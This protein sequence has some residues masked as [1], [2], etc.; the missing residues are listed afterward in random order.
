MPVLLER[1]RPT[2]HQLTA[3]YAYIRR[4][5]EKGK[6]ALAESRAKEEEEKQRRRE[7]EKKKETVD[8]VRKEIAA[9]EA[10]LCKLKREKHELFLQFKKAL[11][12][13]EMKKQRLNQAIVPDPRPSLSFHVPANGGFSPLPHNVQGSPAVMES[14]SDAGKIMVIKVTLT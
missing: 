3:V 12:E 11:N 4:K 9:L 2:R 13:D 10:K 1:T 8:D 5:R 7:E 14:V 6:Q